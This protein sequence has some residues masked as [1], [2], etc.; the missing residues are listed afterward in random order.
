VIIYISEL[1]IP[2]PYTRR[3]TSSLVCE[4]SGVRSDDAANSVLLRY[5]GILDN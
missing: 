4:F 1:N 3:R 2:V 5:G